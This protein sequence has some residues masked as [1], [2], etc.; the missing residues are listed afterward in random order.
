MR[1]VTLALAAACAII[2]PAASSEPAPLLYTL[3]R[4][5]T[6]ASTNSG[7]DY[8]KMEPGGKR[9]FIARDQDGLS[10]FDVDANR[11]VATIV[12]STGANGPLLLPQYDRGYAA[13][14]DGSLL[15]F[16]LKSLK[17]ISRVQLANDGG[18]NSAVHDPA[19]RRIHVIVSSRPEQST[20]FTLDAA[21][22][23]LLGAKT[24]AFRK[25]DDPTS[26]ARGHLFAPVRY[27]NLILRL[28]SETLDELARWPVEC[29][30]SKV[31]FQAHTN[32]ILAACSGNNP[33]FLAID[34]ATGATVAR[35]PIGKGVDGFV[36]DEARRRIVTSNGTD[37]TLTV[38]GQDGPDSYRLLGAVSTRPG[39]RMMT[40]DERTGR[41]LVVNADYTHSPRGVEGEAIK[42][43]HP[44]TFVVLT[45]KPQ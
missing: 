44:N 22:G 9:L 10:V 8:A 36:V 6:L 14:T 31:F 15:S 18:L 37:G 34:A 16:H 35:L 19:T 30:V 1:A 4:S 40:L 28:D 29:N 25:M 27:D 38:I 26:D 33:L 42:T 32:R 39:A 20:W 17:P 3:E 2:A 12:N 23:R 43:F 21:S 24:F 41:L 45:Y 11:L 7:W 13:M 5:V